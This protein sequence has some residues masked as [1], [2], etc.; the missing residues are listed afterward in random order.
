MSGCQRGRSSHG[1][2][3][4]SSSLA[5]STMCLAEVGL[6][7]LPRRAVLG[8]HTTSRGQPPQAR[9]HCLCTVTLCMPCPKPP[10]KVRSNVGSRGSD[11]GTFERSSRDRPASTDVSRPT[12]VRQRQKL[13]QS[14]YWTL[15][16]AATAMVSSAV[17]DRSTSCAIGPVPS[18]GR[19]L[20]ASASEAVTPNT[21][22]L[23]HNL[24]N[25]RNRAFN[26]KAIAPVWIA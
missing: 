7:P 25:D 16:V 23:V 18:T 21:G 6:V 19:S 2:V 9:A 4:R 13:G 12:R 26:R 17:V 10:L 1:S 22:T 15:P 11:R 5:S 14:G 8:P 3:C 24:G 20:P